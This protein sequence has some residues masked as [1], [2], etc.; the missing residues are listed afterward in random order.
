MATTLLH[1]DLY[2]DPA[3]PGS[4]LLF[5]QLP[6]RLQGR[7]CEVAYWPL[8][9]RALYLAGAHL[10][11]AGPMQALPAATPSRW[12]CEQALPSRREAS[13]VAGNNGDDDSAPSRSASEQ[14]GGQRLLQA[15]VNR[16]VVALPTLVVDGYVF[17][18]S[19]ALEQLAAHLAA[20]GGD[21][22]N[23]NDTVMAPSG[24]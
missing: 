17:T 21:N 11:E 8:D 18:G 2:F 12:A 3:A 9:E 13:P 23:D 15:A 10:S 20:G 4:R 24:G 6:E 5:E 19:Q 22:S 7:S 16:G 14:L 1:L